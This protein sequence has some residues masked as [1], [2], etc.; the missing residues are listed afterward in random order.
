MVVSSTRAADVFWRDAFPSYMVPVMTFHASERFSLGLNYLEA[1][2]TDEETCRDGSV[3]VVYVGESKTQMSRSLV[4]SVAAVRGFYPAHG[5]ESI[6]YDV[7]SLRY[8]FQVVG[9]VGIE[10]CGGVEG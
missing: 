6:V 5:G 9:V 10:G 8:F 7:V 2:L 1:S 3:S 4:G